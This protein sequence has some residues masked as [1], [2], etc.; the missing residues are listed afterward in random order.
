M[1]DVNCPYCNAEIEVY[2]WAENKK[3]GEYFERECPEC[4]KNI[5]VCF[6]TTPNF[7]AEEAPCLNGE[8]HKWSKVYSSL[9]GEYLECLCGETKNKISYEEALKKH[10]EAM[11]EYEAKRAKTI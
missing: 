8:E 7:S 3:E 10:N 6:E 11:K 2:D 1:S 9:Y 5:F 4:N